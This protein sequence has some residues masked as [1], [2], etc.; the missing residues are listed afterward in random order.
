MGL[1]L[2]KFTYNQRQV[3]IHGNT[4]GRNRTDVQFDKNGIHTNVEYDT[5]NRSM[6]QHKKVLPTNNPNARNK[7]YKVGR[8]R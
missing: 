1:L 5:Y 8:G 6:Q 4:V 7:F 2:M 3:D